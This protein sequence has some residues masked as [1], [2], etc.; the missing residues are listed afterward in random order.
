MSRELA[1]AGIL[2]L[3][4]TDKL[5]FERIL[6]S[7]FKEDEALLTGIGGALGALIGCGQAA[8]V[9]ASSSDRGRLRDVR[10]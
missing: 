9:L 4:S 3:G 2:K 5:E 10:Q 6:G 8:L 1:A 7:T